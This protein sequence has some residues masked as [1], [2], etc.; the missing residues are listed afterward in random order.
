[1]KISP[2]SSIVDIVIFLLNYDGIQF[3][4]SSIVM[5]ENSEKGKILSAIETI[6]S[7]VQ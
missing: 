1:M 3:V 5:I 4:S 6:Y 2:D 7:I